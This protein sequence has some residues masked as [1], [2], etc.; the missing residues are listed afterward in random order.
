MT[1]FPEQG[2]APEPQPEMNSARRPPQLNPAVCKCCCTL[3]SSPESEDD[4]DNDDGASI[5]SFDSTLVASNQS[6]TYEDF[7]SSSD[8]PEP[9]VTPDTFEGPLPFITEDGFIIDM[10]SRVRGIARATEGIPL[11]EH[12]L[13]IDDRPI[14]FRPGP[15][16]RGHQGYPDSMTNNFYG[17]DGRSIISSGPRSD[18][19][20]VRST[21]PGP[22]IAA[23]IEDDPVVA[24]ESNFLGTPLRLSHQRQYCRGLVTSHLVLH[25]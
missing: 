25:D 9:H 19:M 15:F 4:G 18:F 3:K 12:R 2:E 11:H 5:Q 13:G 10:E 20:D 16:T 6:D 1:R 24:V 23:W 8:G 14:R 22:G 21:S 7:P 17:S